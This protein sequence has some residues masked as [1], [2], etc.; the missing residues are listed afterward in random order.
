MYLLLGCQSKGPQRLTGLQSFAIADSSS[1]SAANMAAD[2]GSKTMTAKSS[3]I[4]DEDFRLSIGFGFGLSLMLSPLAGFP[5]VW[6]TTELDS[7]LR[8][9]SGPC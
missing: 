5:Q 6:R 9:V 8:C 3:N 1:D 4:S 2:I 7:A